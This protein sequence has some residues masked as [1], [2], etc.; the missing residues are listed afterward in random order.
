MIDNSG[1]G[2]RGNHGGAGFDPVPGN[3]G[4]LC[5]MS[6]DPGEVYNGYRDDPQVVRELNDELE[7]TRTAEE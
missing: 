1:D 5:H 6:D 2:W 7:R 3:P 4:Q